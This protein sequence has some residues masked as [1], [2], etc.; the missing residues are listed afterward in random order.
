MIH[1]HPHPHPRPPH[2]ARHK[3][4]PITWCLLTLGL[5]QSLPAMAEEPNWPKTFPVVTLERYTENTCFKWT[6]EAVA[7]AQP[8]SADV[9]AS[10]R[11]ELYRYRGGADDTSINH[12]HVDRNGEVKMYFR[13]EFRFNSP[14]PWDRAREINIRMF[15]SE[16]PPI[17]TQRRVTEMHSGGCAS[18]YNTSECWGIVV[19]N[20]GYD[21][22]FL[23]PG[24]C[25]TVPT[26]VR[27]CVFDTPTGTLTFDHGTVRVGKSSTVSRVV[28]LKCTGGTKYT[29]RAR[30]VPQ[31]VE[32]KV[33]DKALDANG[34]SLQ[35]LGDPGENMG[36]GRV[37]LSS[38]ITPK[39][40]GS[41]RRS[42]VVEI[43]IQ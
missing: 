35:T 22:K 1:A 6:A 17:G 43:N 11:L 25:A 4:H 28:T 12:L 29:L 18:D 41:F 23:P 39:E 2:P 8:F 27:Y 3:G 34:V 38:I 32:L 5:V 7:T 10:W 30:V 37:S 16:D 13:P 24:N 26:P 20:S 14:A 42:A 19:G 9:M 31:D 40:A 36:I 15:G 21:Y 33:G